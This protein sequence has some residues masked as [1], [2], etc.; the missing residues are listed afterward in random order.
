[1]SEKNPDQ[2]KTTPPQQAGQVSVRVR[3]ETTEAAFASQFI[4]NASAEEIIVGLS[5]G[6][7]T[8]P[9]SKENLLPIH[10]RIAMTPG[11]ARRL[12]NALSSALKGLDDA[13]RKAEAPREAELP[14]LDS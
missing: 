9:N 10:G 8:D 11:G 12:I 5:P 13:K 7:V 4:V 14:K 6:F 1:M 3:Y 2:P